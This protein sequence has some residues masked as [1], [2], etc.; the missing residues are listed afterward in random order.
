MDS[1]ISFQHHQKTFWI[2]G[3]KLVEIELEMLGLGCPQI[4]RV[5]F[6]PSAS[7]HLGHVK[8]FLVRWEAAGGKAMEMGLF[9]LS[10]LNWPTIW[11]PFPGQIA[12]LS[13]GFIEMLGQQLTCARD[14][15]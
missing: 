11:D 6:P 12:K 1:I 13:G 9:Q 4:S 10:I 5:P 14:L 3:S 2:N 7:T 15:T 8:N